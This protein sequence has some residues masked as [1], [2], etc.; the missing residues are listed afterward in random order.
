MLVLLFC[1]LFELF[2]LF[3]VRYLGYLCPFFQA[4]Y[5]SSSRILRET[6]ELLSALC[7]CIRAHLLLP[8]VSDY[9]LSVIHFILMLFLLH[10]AIWRVCFAIALFFGISYSTGFFNFSFL[11]FDCDT[12]SFHIFGRLSSWV[13]A[14]YHIFMAFRF[15]DP[16]FV[17]RTSIFL[18]IIYSQSLFHSIIKE[19]H[20]FFSSLSTLYDSMLRVIHSHM[21]FIIDIPC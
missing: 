2:S 18:A 4:R 15:D 20:S 21:V 17:L 14:F 19:I 11:L 6:F 1:S 3:L 5:L 8:L 12:I 7:W 9:A 13:S 16:L 10:S